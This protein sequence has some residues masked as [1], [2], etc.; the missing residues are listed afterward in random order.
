MSAILSIR[1]S[2]AALDRLKKRAAEEGTT[3]EAVAAA[4]LERETPKSATDPLIQCIGMFKSD[5]PDAAER[6]HEYLGQ[7]L[8]EEMTGRAGKTDVR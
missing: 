6:H 8:Y 2:Q 1:V 4:E 3:P 7:A 5:V